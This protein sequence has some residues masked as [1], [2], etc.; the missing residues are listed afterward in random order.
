MWVLLAAIAGSTGRWTEDRAADQAALGKMAGGDGAALAEIYDRHARPVYSL[1]LRIL[2]DAADAEDIVQEVFAQ[3]WRQ[4]PK[5]DPRRGAPAA[6]LLTMARSR[7]IDRLRARRARP[8]AAVR[9]ALLDERGK[10]DAPEIPDSSALPDA[11]LLSAE[12]VARVRKALEDL[13]V[14]Q[15]VALELAFYEGLTHVEIAE[16]LEQPLGTVKTRIRVAML[17]LRD[18]LAGVV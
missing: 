17:R 9:P 15:R 14:L 7:A 3:A 4:A 10:Q 16:R 12:Q 13:P 5:Y 1:A 6:W 2:Q 11:Q 18:A 8:E